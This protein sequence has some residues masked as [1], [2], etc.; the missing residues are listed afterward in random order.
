MD[1]GK[2]EKMLIRYNWITLVVTV[3]AIFFILNLF[4]FKN[5]LEHPIPMF[6]AGDAYWHASYA[7]YI[8][9][10]GYY[11]SQPQYMTGNN[12]AKLT[13]VEPPLFFYL[14]AEIGYLLSINYY[15]ASIIACVLIMLCGVIAVYLLSNHINPLMPYFSLPVTIMQSC[16]P[17]ISGMSWGFWK[18]Y[19]ASVLLIVGM[20]A[21]IIMKRS[22]KR[23]IL[24]GVIFAGAIISHASMLLYVALFFA[25]VFLQEA[26]SKRRDG[27]ILVSVAMTITLALSANYLI[28]F[29]YS[30]FGPGQLVHF[31]YGYGMYGATPSVGSMGLFFVLGAAG[32]I[33]AIVLRKNWPSAEVTSYCFGTIFVLLAIGPFFDMFMRFL[34]MRIFWPL[35]TAVFV[36]FFFITML[37][38]FESKK[39]MKSI[40]T[41]SVF[42]V[43]TGTILYAGP[44]TYVMADYVFVEDGYW[45]ILENV[46]VQNNS[47]VLL[48]DPSLSQDAIVYSVHT[49]TRYLCENDFQNNRS[50]E[51]FSRIFCSVPNYIRTGLGWKECPDCETYCL[52]GAVPLCSFDYFVIHTYITSSQSEWVNNQL[53]SINKNVN[54]SVYLK[55]EDAVILKNENRCAL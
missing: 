33:C 24:V 19:L 15:D 14:N 39:Y 16:F 6:K 50:V 26:F 45:Y 21:W 5:S 38:V 36:G 46:P 43:F 30:W 2:I 22:T 12:P 18:F 54:V 48:I 55:N 44:S 41:L 9:D 42:A 23:S 11:N 29:Y 17:F 3:V 34:Q 1:M 7:K 4:F 40:I 47:R 49:Y 37:R 8:Q 27:V 51:N 32:L 25:I 31:G 13:P 52:E 20:V 28:D 35:I 10:T 53:S